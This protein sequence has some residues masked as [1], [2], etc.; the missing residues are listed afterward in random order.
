MVLRAWRDRGAHL[1]VAEVATGG[2]L[3]ASLNTAA[4][5]GT[6][7]AASFA[8][9]TEERLARLVETPP[10]RWRAAAAAEERVGVLAEAAAAHAGAEWGIAVGEGWLR[11]NTVEIWL[12][13]RGGGHHVT[14]RLAARSAA[15]AD[16]SALVTPALDRLRRE[17]QTTSAAAL[18]HPDAAGVS[19]SRGPE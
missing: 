18:G 7:V 10:G 3:G 13:I 14:H 11:G 12:A 6:V 16:T 1:A 2:A 8:A 9:P 5:A 17:L 4:E 15:G 19:R